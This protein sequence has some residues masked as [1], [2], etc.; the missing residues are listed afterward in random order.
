MHPI[1]VFK[2][3]GMWNEA[4]S[5]KEVVDTILCFEDH[6]ERTTFA[7]TSL[8]SQ[9]VILGFTWLEEHNPKIDWQTWNVRR[10]RCPKKC[11]TCR[12]EVNAER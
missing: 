6:T 11:Q 1:P 7:V 3:D 8:G 5:I 9:A 12:K 2:V 10:S 4:G